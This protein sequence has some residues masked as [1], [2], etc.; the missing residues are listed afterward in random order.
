[1]IDQGADI[2]GHCANESGIGAINA[3]S[4]AGLYSTGDSY[5]QSSLAPQSVLSSAVYNVPQLI[6]SA[7]QDIMDGNFVGEV[8]QLGMKEGIVEFVYN[9]ELEEKIPAEVKQLIDEKIAAITSGEFT[10]PCDTKDRQAK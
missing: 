1:M 3:A 10:V 7:V 9:P 2:I 4:D 5:D 8:K 6:K